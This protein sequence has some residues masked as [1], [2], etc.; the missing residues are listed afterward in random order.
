LQVLAAIAYAGQP[1]AVLRAGMTKLPQVL[2]NVPVQGKLDIQSHPDIQRVQDD[3]TSTLAGR[4]RVL[5]RASGT[6]P[7][8]R[9]MVEGDNEDEITRL[10]EQVAEVIATAA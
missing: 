7:V 6:E 4:G 3:V 10:A 2:I 5:L 1:L 8:I 9:V